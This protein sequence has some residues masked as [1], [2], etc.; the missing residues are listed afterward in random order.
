MDKKIED[1]LLKV[2]KPARYV[3]GEVN[4]VVKSADKLKFAFCF[5][6]IYEIGMS[7]LGMKILYSLINKQEDW[8]CERVF[9]PDWD[10]RQ[11]LIENDVPLFSLESHTSLCDFDMIGF[12]LQYEMSFTAILDMLSLGKVPV[13]SKDRPN[14]IVIA[15]G[16]CACNPEPL[17]DFIDLFILGEGEEV[18]IELL[19]LYKQ[20]KGN[21]EEFLLHAK[22]IEGVYV[23]K[24]YDINYNN[25]GTVKSISPEKRIKK[26]VIKDLDNVYY[27]DNFIVPFIDIVH[28]RAIAEVMRG[29][30]RG[31][32][33]CQAGFIYRPLREK[34]ADTLQKNC[35][36]L[37]QSTGYEEISLSSL[38]TSDYSKLEELLK[39]VYSYSKDNNI[40]FT[41]PSLRIDNFP[42]ELL[43]EITSV[44]KSGLTFAP[45]AGTQRMRDVINK[46]ITEEDVLKSCATAFSGGYTSV[47]LYFMIGLPNETDED[48]VGIID[49]AQKVVDSFYDMED[50]PKGKGV[51]VTVSVSTFVPKP[52]TPFQFDPQD[53]MEEIVRKQKLLRDSIKSKKIILK[54]HESKISVVEA[55]LARGDRRLCDVIMSAW[56][57]GCILEEHSFDKWED[58]FKEN[59]LSMNFYANRKREYDE[60]FPWEHLDYGMSK[61]FFIREHKKAMLAETTKNCKQQCSG[62]G[63][64][65]MGGKYCDK[66]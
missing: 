12:T 48:V 25:D 6:D 35:K 59:N 2:Q 50:R 47:K 45:E 51:T 57:K 17:V 18:N 11:Q 33:F 13:L 31:C 54:C 22:D 9:A 63:I 24:Y 44:R 1:M 10:F 7:H 23:P 8:W 29:C 4:Q 28:D 32:R 38:S 14:H 56:K 42:K 49:L 37:C 21:K 5:P 52:F 43:D 36:D 3:G 60:V 41:L 40:N 16:P 34:Q 66:R 65:N 46:N 19:N 20:Y 62:C 55:T 30:I 39:G 58:S 64:K 15:G 26:R 61:N 27:P 53:T